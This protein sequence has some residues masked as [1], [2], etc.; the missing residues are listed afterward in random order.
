MK[1]QTYR[2]HA[3]WFPMFHFVVLPFLLIYALR[4]IWL[5]YQAGTSDSIWAMAFAIVVFL[6][7][8]ASRVMALKVQDR[9]IRLEM[10]LRLSTILPGDLRDKVGSLTSD[11]LIGLRFACDSELPD[12]V[13]RVLAGELKERKAIKQA[14]KT[15]EPD[16][17]RA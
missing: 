17:M 7:A 14:V 11:Q 10:R 6:A 16:W 3:A 12:L 4:A 5:A 15:W 13:R 1:D 8:L 2:N 9:L